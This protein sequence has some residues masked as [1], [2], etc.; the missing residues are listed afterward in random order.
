MSI[1][2]KSL[3]EKIKNME[4]N[5]ISVAL[6]VV[7]VQHKFCENK[8]P[9][10]GNKETEEIS[11]HIQELIPAFRKAS[12]PVYAIYSSGAKYNG[13]PGFYKFTPD[14]TDTLVMKRKDSAFK[15]SRIK[16]LL[17]KDGI[18]TIIACGFNEIACVKK[19]LLDA[20]KLGFD[21]YLLHDLSGNDAQNKTDPAYLSSGQA[22]PK[23]TINETEMKEHGVEFIKSTPKFLRDIGAI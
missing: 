18:D 12:I 6:L 13:N 15:G 11:E 9:Y 14:E 1:D 22:D 19:T 20:R 17:K 7:D 8:F 4:K 16:R 23:I 21:T 2:Y 5:N 10:R 3:V